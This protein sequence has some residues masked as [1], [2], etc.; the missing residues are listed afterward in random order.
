LSSKIKPVRDCGTPLASSILRPND[1]W[2]LLSSARGLT[3]L[4]QIGTS[5]YGLY[6]VQEGLYLLP[7]IGTSRLIHGEEKKEG[8]LK[9]K[10]LK[11]CMYKLFFDV[12]V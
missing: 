7:Q 8:R 5:K 6:P 10:H 3:S 12:R 1:F 4:P 2:E 9:G 11:W